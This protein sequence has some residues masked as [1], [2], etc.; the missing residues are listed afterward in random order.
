MSA[1]AVEAPFLKLG[2]GRIVN[3]AQVAAF[4]LDGEK[5]F[6]HYGGKIWSYTGAEARRVW[7]WVERVSFAP[8]GGR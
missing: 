4:H 8:A 2:P 3:L 1:A 5:L 6:V 7:E